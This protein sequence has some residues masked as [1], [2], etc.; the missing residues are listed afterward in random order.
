VVEWPQMPPLDV[1]S[2]IGRVLAFAVGFVAFY[3]AFFLYEDEDGLWQNRLDD[4][5]VR[6]HERARKT[7]SISTA[8]VNKSCELL[9]RASDHVFG[10]ALFSLQMVVVSLY[11][12]LSV[13]PIIA[14]IKDRGD[15]LGGSSNFPKV[16]AVCVAVIV[17][18]IW[19]PRRGI[20]LC[21]L[22]PWVWVLVYFA[23]GI[24]VTPVLPEGWVWAKSML[25]VV[26]LSITSDVCAVAF[27]RRTIRAISSQAS[28]GSVMSSSFWLVLFSML[29]G[30]PALTFAF[31]GLPA[32]IRHTE[33][34]DLVGYFIFM[35]LL[36]NTFTVIYL[37][38]PVFIFT[39]LLAHRAF[40]P[41]L[42]R[43]LYPLSRFKLLANRKA[44]GALGCL[45][46]TFAFNIETVGAKELVKLLS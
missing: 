31:I 19:K 10:N 2:I 43:M 6:I 25:V 29:V 16:F 38:G 30:L 7:D 8:L 32:S 12:S 21:F 27:V 17:V 36:F 20:L 22:L 46:W 15:F 13:V 45:A 28:P 33:A 44:M 18:S 41:T 37:I 9:L 5:W 23:H 34:G 24:L 1:L 26:P 39:G 42:C 35:N 14:F 11:L 3:L 4:L 40:W